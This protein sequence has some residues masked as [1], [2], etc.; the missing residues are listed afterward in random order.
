[1]ALLHYM[2]FYALI[3]LAPEVTQSAH[4]AS[5]YLTSENIRIYYKIATRYEK[6]KKNYALKD[7]VV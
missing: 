2:R 7:I 6:R 5:L 3:I 1:M 4:E